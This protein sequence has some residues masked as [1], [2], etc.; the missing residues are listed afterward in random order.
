MEILQYLVG[1]PHYYRRL[2]V[3]ARAILIASMITI[4]MIGMSNEPAQFIYFQF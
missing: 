2:A 4:T 1:D 3:P